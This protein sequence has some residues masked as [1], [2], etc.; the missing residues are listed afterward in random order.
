MDEKLIL[1][2]GTEISGHM[3]QSGNRL[4]LYMYEIGLE[5]AFNLLIDPE[6]TK[7]IKY[8]RYSDSG[9]V[10]G[11]KRLMSISVELDGTMI[12]AS[13]AK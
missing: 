11:Y 8:Q 6:R 9:T 4:F 5:D 1:N 2:D 12:C 10:K 7:A 3:I 13:L